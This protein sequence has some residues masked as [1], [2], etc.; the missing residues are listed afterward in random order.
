MNVFKIVGL[1]LFIQVFLFLSNSFLIVR[2]ITP[3]LNGELFKIEVISVFILFLREPFRNACKRLSYE[4]V[5]NLLAFIYLPLVVFIYSTS[6]IYLSTFIELLSEPFL[7]TLN[8]NKKYETKYLIGNVSLYSKTLYILYFGTKNEFKISI[9]IEAQIFYSVILFITSFASC[10]KL[11]KTN[12]NFSFDFSYLLVYIFQST[13]HY[14]LSEGEKLFLFYNYNKRVQ[15]LYEMT[16]KLG[17]IIP[18]KLFA[19]LEDICNMEFSR[20]GKKEA[21][22]LFKY[23]LKRL[24]VFSLFFIS[25]FSFYTKDFILLVYGENW[26][27]V[28]PLL[29]CF[30]YYI[31]FLSIN[32]ISESLIHGIST[33]E[34]MK[35]TQIIMVVISIFYGVFIFIFKDFGIEYLIYSNIFNL[36]MRIIYSFYY[37]Y[38]HFGY[39]EIGIHP[40]ILIQFLLF[41][42]FHFFICSMKLSIIFFIYQGLTILLIG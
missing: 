28:A 3:E 34:D 38:N 29:S 18:R 6:F 35:R 27:Q 23:Y 12:Y 41:W 26:I 14:L 7:I 42:I 13:F 21:L 37:I 39:F 25:F 36:S 10:Y 8:H 24:I 31:L 2:K 30:C 11:I 33:V 19:P 4:K 16:I 1:N 15:G 32:G 9:F 17:S 40:I 22:I 5:F 20:I